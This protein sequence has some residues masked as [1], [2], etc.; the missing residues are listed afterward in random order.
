M[1]KESGAGAVPANSFDIGTR[2]DKHVNRTVIP[3]KG[4]TVAVSAL[5]AAAGCAQGT[6]APQ[7]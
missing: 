2:Q 3:P 7:L 4:S 5:S 6:I 1:G